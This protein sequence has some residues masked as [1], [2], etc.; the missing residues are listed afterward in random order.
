MAV[1]YERSRF[2]SPEFDDIVR[3]PGSLNV[4]IKATANRSGDIIPIAIVRSGPAPSD[5][6]VMSTSQVAVPL[7]EAMF[8]APFPTPAIV[9]HITEYVAGVAAG[10]N[11]QTHITLKTVIDA[12]E[13]PAFATHFRF[14]RNCPLLSVHPPHLVRGRRSGIRGFLRP[15]AL[16]GAPIEATNSPCSASASLSDLESRLPADPGV[17]DEDADL[18]RCAYSLGERL[19]LALYRHLGEERFLQG[20]REPY[21]ALAAQPTYPVD[22]DFPEVELRVGWLRA[23]GRLM[24][25][26]L[27]HIWDQW[28]RGTASTIVDGAPDPAAPDP[29]LPSV[30]GRIDSAHVSL[31]Q[32]GTPT[33]SFSASEQQGWVFLT[34][35]YS[36]S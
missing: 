33:D 15:H 31:T 16:S 28:Y 2:Q 9:I 18:G 6:P 27:E 20:W 12:N 13:N 8:D 4:E 29:N 22:Y 32:F 26:E 5:S 10:T 1:L 23:G 14:P 30:N 7:F 34:L 21:H 3:D 25:P 17:G 11:F 36:T 24:Q 35:D 19:M